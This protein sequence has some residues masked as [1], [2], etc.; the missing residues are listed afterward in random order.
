[1]KSDGGVISGVAT[2]YAFTDYK[3]L[4][5]TIECMMVNIW[6]NKK[7]YRRPVY[8]IRGVVTVRPSGISTSEYL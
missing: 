4:G 6:P 8:S 5:Q 3:E 1:V 7:I 2:M